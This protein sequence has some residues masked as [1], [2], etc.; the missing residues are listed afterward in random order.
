[1]A[2]DT[3]SKQPTGITITA[4]GR[5]SPQSTLKGAY[6]ICY[7][8][9]TQY[10]DGSTTTTMTSAPLAGAHPGPEPHAIAVTE[11]LQEVFDAGLQGLPVEVLSTS[12][13][14][15][16][17]PP[18]GTW[19]PTP[20]TTIGFLEAAHS[21]R[22]V[23]AQFPKLRFEL[24]EGG[25]EDRRLY[26]VLAEAMAQAA[27]WAEERLAAIGGTGLMPAHGVGPSARRG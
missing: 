6:A 4:A 13:V 7:A 27:V 5:G 3:H 17:L 16:D 15:C 8:V 25:H 9:T 22:E 11:A 12:R 23:A 26:G 14:V 2:S 19:K 21:L 10:E 24:A 20:E 1:M 18:W